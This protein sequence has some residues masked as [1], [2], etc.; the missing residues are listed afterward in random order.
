MSEGRCRP[1]ACAGTCSCAM[2]GAGSTRVRVEDH[3]VALRVRVKK[4]RPGLGTLRSNERMLVA[5]DQPTLWG[6][7]KMCPT[8]A[9]WT[10]RSCASRRTGRSISAG[11]FPASSSLRRVDGIVTVPSVQEQRLHAAQ[12]RTFLRRIQARKCRAHSVWT[13]PRPSTFAHPFAGTRNGV[14]GE[15]CRRRV[16]K[17]L[18]HLPVTLGHLVVCRSTVA[19]TARLCISSA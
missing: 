11:P 8:L 7:E 2:T 1:A 10:R 4:E 18:E 12:L 17:K 5:L 6:K 3:A 19:A 16:F 13:Q 14:D 15:G 9:M